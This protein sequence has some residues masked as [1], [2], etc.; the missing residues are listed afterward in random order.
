M[1]PYPSVAVAG[2]H[3]GHLGTRGRVVGDRDPQVVGGKLGRPEVTGHRDLYHGCAA[4]SRGAAVLRLNTK[5]RK[6]G[7]I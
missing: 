1:A 2:L 3:L 6:E 7:N 5:L 4:L